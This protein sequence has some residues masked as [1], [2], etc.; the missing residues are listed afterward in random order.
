[1]SAMEVTYSIL[2]NLPF[3]RHSKCIANMLNL[4]EYLKIIRP[5]RHNSSQIKLRIIHGKTYK[6]INNL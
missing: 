3:I 4:I 5:Y 2:H 6:T 1:M